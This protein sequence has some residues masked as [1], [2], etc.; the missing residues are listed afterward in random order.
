M[1]CLCAQAAR[2]ECEVIVV[3]VDVPSAVEL[4]EPEAMGRFVGLLRSMID[5]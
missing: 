4:V 3:I 5:R 1:L 2:K